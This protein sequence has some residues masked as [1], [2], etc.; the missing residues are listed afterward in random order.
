MVFGVL[1]AMLGGQVAAHFVMPTPIDRTR[2]HVVSPGLDERIQDPANGRGVYIEDGALTLRQHAFH[3]AEILS[4]TDTRTVEKVVLEVVSGSVRLNWPGPTGV[5]FAILGPDAAVHGHQATERYSRP[6]GAPWVVEVVD[7]QVVLNTAR[8]P[9]TLGPASGGSVELTAVSDEVRISRVSVTDRDGHPALEADYRLRATPLAHWVGGALLGLLVGGTLR[10]ATRSRPRGVREVELGLLLAVPLAVCAIPPAD[11]LYLVERAYLVRTPAWGLARTLLALSLAPAVALALMRSGVLVPP[12]VRSRLD[13]RLAW[14]GLAI[15]AAVAAGV[16]GGPTLTTAVATLVGLPFLLLPMRVARAADQ[17]ILG[18]LLVDAPASIAVFSLGWGWGLLV[19]VC[20]RVLT[21]SA[22]AGQGLLRTA[23][24]PTTDLLF[25]MVLVFPLSL[26]LAVRDT[27]LQEGWDLARLSGDLAPSV[28]WQDP[29]PFWSHTC[30]DPG[31]RPLRIVWM[32]GSS[33]GGAYQFRDQPTAFYPAQAHHRV[34][35]ALPDGV[36]LTSEN[37]GD[38]GRDTFT[39]SRSLG[40]IA[41]RSA[42]TLVVVY[43]GVNDLLTMSGTKTRAQREAERSKRDAATTGLASVGAQS[44]LLTG[45]GLFLRPLHARDGARVPEVP[46]ADAAEN[47]ATIAHIADQHEARVLLLAEVIRTD[48]SDPLAPYADLEAQVAG[49]LGTVEAFDLRAALAS[50]GPWN[51]Q[52]MLVD[53]NHLSRAGSARV[54]AALVPP[55]SRLLGLP[56]PEA[57]DTEPI[58]AADF[59]SPRASGGAP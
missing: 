1:G 27:Y 50:Q 13:G 11:W 46:L 12:D 37:Y 8:G 22:S 47:F 34:C 17:P 24:R 51:D 39:I 56:T 28:G 38:G 57:I 21:V 2:W 5:T 52:A 26:E 20:W 6:D 23:P 43:T 33:T 44:R 18:A 10:A 48:A 55:V 25:A 4:P 15:A 30:G 36:L 14:L 3:R 29:A 42:L 40:D 9:V 41:D 31:G 49:R 35:A 32:G 53:Q 45:I 54:G 58:P 59:R 19:A 7:Q 16:Q